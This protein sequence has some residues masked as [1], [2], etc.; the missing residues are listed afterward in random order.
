M[1]GDASLEA[2]LRAMLEQASATG[3]EGDLISSLTA[4]LDGDAPSTTTSGP[5]EVEAD[6]PTPAGAPTPTSS[7]E[8][9]QGEG[10]GP[11]PTEELPSGDF[12]A[13]AVAAGVD[14]P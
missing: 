4:L 11:N 3:R 14:D 2:R 13:T 1:S 9:E 5:A 7:P 10:N 6:L 12:T 8:E